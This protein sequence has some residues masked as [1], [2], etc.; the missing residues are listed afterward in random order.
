MLPKKN[1]VADVNSKKSLKQGT[2]F[3]FFSK[4]STTTEAP[5]QPSQ[6]SSVA[7]SSSDVSHG[8]NKDFS[9]RTIEKPNV[10]TSD[11]LSSHLK[12]GD[13]IEVYWL[14]DDAWYQAKVMKIK[15]QN[16]KHFIEYFID[17]QSE[18][19]NLSTESFRLLD[20]NAGSNR[21]RRCSNLSDDDDFGEEAEFFMPP[22]DD[23]GSTYKDEG[24]DENEEDDDDQW[25]VTDDEEEDEMAPHKRRKTTARGIK[26]SE[27]KKKKMLCSRV[28]SGSSSSSTLREFS[29]GSV[30]ISLSERSPLISG[31]TPPMR[32]NSSQQMTTPPQ[33]TPGTT[34]SATHLS[35]NSVMSA[36]RMID[37]SGVATPLAT[38]KTP[39]KFMGNTSKPPMFEIGA[40]NPAGSHVHNHLPFLQNPRDG[41]G[42]LPDDPQYDPR[43]LQIIDRDWIRI[44]GKGM[45]DAVKQWW[46]LKAMYFDTVLLF[47]T[48][49][50]ESRTLWNRYFIFLSFLLSSTFRIKVNFMKCFIWMP[51]LVCKYVAYAT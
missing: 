42:R 43:T 20:S 12:I 19:I 45:T 10:D 14:E 49:T 32:I 1:A 30:P 6:T 31:T 47:K 50:L 9:E 26:P 16:P 48:G 21:K 39:S 23:E 7:A 15:S 28:N 34:A 27:T 11:S 4:K 51:T 24:N 46:D 36:N 25:M 35:S 13:M 2:L 33:I 38:Q 3:S 17:G 18:W 37:R 44:T 22:S 29:A 5:P 8:P 41:A 40:L